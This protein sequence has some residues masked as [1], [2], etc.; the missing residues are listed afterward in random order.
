M[1]G[2]LFFLLDLNKSIARQ[3][4]ADGSEV[5]LL[6]DASVLLTDLMQVIVGE[7]KRKVG[8]VHRRLAR[9]QTPTHSTPSRPTRAL[10][11]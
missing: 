2:E 8:D 7:D 11:L 1:H 3:V 4:Q 5:H 6:G 9:R 10:N